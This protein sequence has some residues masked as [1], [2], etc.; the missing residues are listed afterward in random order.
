[1]REPLEPMAGRASRWIPWIFAS[2]MA[3]VVAV[4]IVMVWIALESSPGLVTEHP[5]ERGLAYN[6]VLADEARQ[7]ALGWRVEIQFR[8]ATH[9]LVAEFRD[10]GGTPLGE[11][12][13]KA[14]LYRPVEADPGLSAKLR[15]VGE[16]RYVGTVDLLRRGQWQVDLVASR[17]GTD[18]QA[19]RRLSVP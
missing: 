3:L 1:M 15:H 8:S 4:N 6:K 19:S 2:G 7:E 17:D 14:L 13:V 9:E 18:F 16:G 11:L 12:Q 10:R 5:F